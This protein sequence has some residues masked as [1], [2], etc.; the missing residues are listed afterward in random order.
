MQNTIHNQANKSNLEISINYI[1]QAP[2]LQE[3]KQVEEILSDQ[4]I[5]VKELHNQLKMI[6]EITLN[7]IIDYLQSTNKLVIEKNGLIVYIHNPK[8]SN[9]IKN[10]PE[11]KI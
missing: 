7:A 4:D 3:V 11:I 8:L 10:R 9:K 2:T 5:T 1:N 6:D